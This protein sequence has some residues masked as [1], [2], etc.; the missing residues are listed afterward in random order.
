MLPLVTAL[1]ANGIGQLWVHHTGH[2][3]TKGYGTKT[4]EWQM[5]TVIHLTEITRPD[6][7][8]SFSLT[9]PKPASARQTPGAILR[10]WRSH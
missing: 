9:F 5:D 10:R 8:V 7:D 6:T 4:R 2:D 1:T 3:T